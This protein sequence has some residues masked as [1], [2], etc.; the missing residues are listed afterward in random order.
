MASRSRRLVVACCLALAIAGAASLA[1]AASSASLAE[2]E[3]AEIYEKAEAYYRNNFLAKALEHYLIVIERFPKTRSAPAA[4]Y[5]VAQIYEQKASPD[6]ALYFYDLLVSGYP[7]SPYAVEAHF[8][9]GKL[10]QDLGRHDSAVTAL[11][12]YTNVAGAKR[13]DEARLLLAASYLALKRYEDALLAYAAGTRHADR[14]AQV[15]ALKQARE[16]IDEH[17]EPAKLLNLLPR[18]AEGAIADFVRY[19]AAEDLARQNRRAEAAKLLR[20]MNFAK[21]PYK[22]YEKAEA[23]LQTVESPAAPS[24]SPKDTTGGFDSPTP[25]APVPTAVKGAVGVI[26]PLSGADAAFGQEVLQGIMMGVDLFGAAPGQGF[27]VVLKDDQ[28]DPSTAA[29]LVNELADDPDVLAIIGPLLGKCAEAAAVEAERR[30]VPLIALT[31]RD[32]VLGTGSWIF[33]NSVTPAAQ[34]KTLIQYATLHQGAFRFAVLYPDNTSGRLF[35]DLFA[36][37]LDQSRYRL[38]ATVAY[39]PNLT[40]FKHAIAQLRAHGAFDALFIPDSA[41]EVALLAPQ[42]VYYGI[43]NVLLLGPSGWNHEELAK[44]AGA[45]LTRAVFV[46]A[47]FAGSRQNAAVEPFVRF[48]QDSF[49]RSPTL[50]AAVGYDTARLLTFVVGSRAASDRGAVRRELL[51]VRNFAGVTGELTCGENRDVQRRLVLLRVSQTQIEELF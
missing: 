45:Y 22:F 47:F 31:A 9:L 11:N 21:R 50:L 37:N 40:D 3:A 15:E 20:E 12:Y 44:L 46:D 34:V 18:L 42:L 32:E 14:D 48:Y 2:S 33:R 25:L 17:L 6:K 27:R 5:K 28:G 30:G 24:A 51:R 10:N 16:I 26:L 23:L 43:T 8:Q 1:R 13:P 38:I 19:R 49:H 36:A 39:A 29:K 7:D 4:T 41:R 35:R